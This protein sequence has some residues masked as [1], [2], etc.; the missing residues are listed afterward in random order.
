M[1]TSK[2]KKN[3][4]KKKKKK[5]KKKKKKSTKKRKKRKLPSTHVCTWHKKW[6]PT[7]ERPS[8]HGREKR[9][10]SMTC[11]APSCVT[12]VSAKNKEDCLRLVKAHM[13]N[14]FKHRLDSIQGL[15]MGAEFGERY[16]SCYAIYKMT[17]F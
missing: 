13:L 5:S 8:K 11:V 14:D 10:V 2:K 16:S 3:K 12:K 6:G 1:G 15:P 17:G 9:K 4:S 7:T